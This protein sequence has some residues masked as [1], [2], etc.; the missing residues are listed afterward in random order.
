MSLGAVIVPLITASF[1]MVIPSFGLSAFAPFG[2]MQK[3]MPRTAFPMRLC[4]VSP[5]SSVS[6]SSDISATSISATPGKRSTAPRTLAAQAAQSVPVTLY[7]CCALVLSA[8]SAPI[9]VF[10]QIST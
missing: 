2:E 1:G 4:D 8:I 5:S 7:S 10:R 3:L 9:L 6:R